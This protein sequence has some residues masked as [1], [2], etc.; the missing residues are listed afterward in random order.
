[1]IPVSIIML[2]DSGSFSPLHFRYNVY[3]VCNHNIRY[4]T[5]KNRVFIQR[6]NSFLKQKG[7][8]KIKF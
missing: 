7:N 2:C 6:A 4:R 3:S 5:N 8:C 1:M